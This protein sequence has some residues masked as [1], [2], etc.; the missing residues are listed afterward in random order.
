MLGWDR[1]RFR[2]AGVCAKPERFA[3]DYIV[4][5][6]RA[7]YDQTLPVLSHKR[8]RPEVLTSQSHTG[9]GRD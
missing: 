8:H 3:A 5:D 6:A 1:G 9:A 7:G 2:A 4:R